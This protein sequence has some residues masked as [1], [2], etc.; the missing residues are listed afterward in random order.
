MNKVC[1]ECGLPIRDGE[2]V[3]AKV[4]SIFHEI[5]SGVSYCIER[6]YACLSIVHL[7]CVPDK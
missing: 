7:D 6:P 4:L 2:H 3:E 1:R 5:P